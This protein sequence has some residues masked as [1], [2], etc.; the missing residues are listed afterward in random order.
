M[1]A[2]DNLLAAKVAQVSSARCL[3]V[4]RRCIV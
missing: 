2:Q 3:G 4:K 1:E